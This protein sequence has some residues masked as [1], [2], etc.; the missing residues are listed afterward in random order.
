MTE[1]RCSN[2]HSFGFTKEL[3]HV[4]PACVHGKGCT[5][6]PEVVEKKKRPK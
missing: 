2:G 6:I 5:G 4:C 1:A 3:P